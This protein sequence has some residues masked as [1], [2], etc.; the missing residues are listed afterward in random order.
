M[1]RVRLSRAPFPDQ[2][3]DVQEWFEND[4]GVAITWLWSA[5]HL[6]DLPGFR[7]TGKPIAISGATIYRF[8]GA[9]RITG[10]W[11]VTDR[12]GVFRQLQQGR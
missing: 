6:G 9:N 3:F 7:A 4:E 11:Q 8:D 12:L 1:E 2:R 10:H 5:T